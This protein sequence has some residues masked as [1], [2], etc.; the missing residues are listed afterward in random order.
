MKARWRDDVG[1]VAWR[2]HAGKFR[3]RSYSLAGEWQDNNQ[4]I[5][6]L[7]NEIIAL[8]H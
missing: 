3:L 1:D 6:D 4:D 7:I 5:K 2:R 8:Q